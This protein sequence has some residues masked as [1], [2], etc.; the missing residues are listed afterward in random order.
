MLGELIAR[1]DDPGAAEEA[2]I[3]S[4]DIMLLARVRAEAEY[5]GQSVGDFAA[6]VVRRFMDGAGDEEWVQLIGAMNRSD[7]PGLAAI[8]TILA[9]AVGTREEAA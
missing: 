6:S 9:R 2:L 8:R 1:L 3:E 4:G 5:L 7:T